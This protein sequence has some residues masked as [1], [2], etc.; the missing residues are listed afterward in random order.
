MHCFILSINIVLLLLQVPRHKSKKGGVK[1]RV[2][3]WAGISWHCKTPGMA[4]TAADTKVVYRHTK[5]ICVGTVF[6]DVDD[7]TGEKIVFRVVETRAGGNDTHVWYVPHFDFPDEDPPRDDWE[8]SSYGEVK[9]WHD[10]S[11]AALAQHPEL[12]PPTSMQDTAKTLQIYRDALYPTLHTWGLTDIVEDNASPHNNDAIRQSH[13]DNNAR[14]VGYTAT[15]AEKEQIKALI[16]Q[17]VAGYRREQDQ[18]AQMTKQTRE[19]DRL[20]AWPP[21]SPDLNLIEVVWSWMV[22]W[23]RDSDGGWPANPEDLKVKV[24]EAWDAVP[25]ESFRELIRSYRV[26]LQAIDSV[27]GDRHPQF[28]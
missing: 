6:E 15:P 27:D 1:K 26:R 28:A 10:S 24:L 16:R 7:D 9:E 4:W 8:H 18:R 13:R 14:I 21:N 3:F 5:N 2:Y 17:Q 25:L 11:R 23:I 19:L 22:R 12:Q 20:P